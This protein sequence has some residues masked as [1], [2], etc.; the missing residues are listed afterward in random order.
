MLLTPHQRPDR[1]YEIDGFC[2]DA[3]AVLGAAE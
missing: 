1:V 2:F 3:C